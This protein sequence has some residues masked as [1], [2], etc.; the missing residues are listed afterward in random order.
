ML[1]KLSPLNVREEELNGGS[2][3]LETLSHQ[4]Y[5]VLYE[6]RCI[7]AVI[8]MPI[9]LKYTYTYSSYIVSLTA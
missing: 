3:E 2:F 4:P 9:N 8:T 1:P 5:M 7:N 6:L